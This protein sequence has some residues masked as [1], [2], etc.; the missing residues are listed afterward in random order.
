MLLNISNHSS[1]NWKPEQNKAA[2]QYGRVI[3][4]PYP[5]LKP[6]WDC[7]KIVVCARDCFDLCKEMIG[8]EKELSAVHLTGEPVFCSVLSQLL[9]REEYKC[10]TST[11]ERKAMVKNGIKISY[12]K[13]VCF[14]NYVLL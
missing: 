4:I 2:E 6:E 5:D 9:M 3:D 10:I 1:K 12:Y 14:R 11:S 13:F 7:Q 8:Q